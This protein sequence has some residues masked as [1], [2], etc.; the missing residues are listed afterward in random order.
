MRLEDR[1]D[2]NVIKVPDAIEQQLV[3]IINRYF[4]TDPIALQNSREAIITELQK[5]VQPMVANMVKRIAWL[6]GKQ[7]FEDELKAVIDEETAGILKEV[8]DYVHNL[9]LDAVTP[10][11]YDFD[12]VSPTSVL[13]LNGTRKLDSTKDIINVYV[14][15][16]LQKVNKNYNLVINA[17][18]N[19]DSITFGTSLENGDTVAVR[20]LSFAVTTK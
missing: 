13:P 18:G 2:G 12:I 3:K 14:N 16:M 7:I 19:V 9:S 6:E 5:R 15:G 8:M 1:G 10:V 11:D 17:V 4:I 20:G